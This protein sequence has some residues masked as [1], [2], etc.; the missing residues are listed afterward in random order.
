[1]YL[2]GLKNHFDPY[3]R[4]EIGDVTTR[5]ASMNGKKNSARSKRTAIFLG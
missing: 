1:V 3:Y 2:A 5:I 4:D